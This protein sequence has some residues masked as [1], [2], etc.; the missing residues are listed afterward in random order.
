MDFTASFNN[1]SII[2]WWS[3]LL[4]GENREPVENHQLKGKVKP[5]IIMPQ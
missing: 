1:I 4:V 3:V 5:I 2:S